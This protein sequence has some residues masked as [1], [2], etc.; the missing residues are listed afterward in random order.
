MKAMLKFVYMECG[1]GGGGGGGRVHE[2][3]GHCGCRSGLLPVRIL[4]QWYAWI[5]SCTIIIVFFFCL[6]NYIAVNLCI[7]VVV[8]VVVCKYIIFI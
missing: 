7:N 1:G 8:V 5:K 6:Y 3:L 2:K 4:S